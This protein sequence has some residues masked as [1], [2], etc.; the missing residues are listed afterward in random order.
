MIDNLEI[1]E[2]TETKFLGVIIDNKLSW[3]S[4]IK[5]LK[6]KLASCSGSISRISDSL[7]EELHIDLYHTLFESYLTYGI[8]VWGA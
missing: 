5:S 7:P 8:T 1:E 2:V 3:E 6:K 4:H